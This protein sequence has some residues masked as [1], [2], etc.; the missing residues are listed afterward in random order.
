MV[1]HLRI[2]ADRCEDG[3]RCMA[4]D[5]ALLERLEDEPAIRLYG[6]RRPTLSLGYFQDHDRVLAILPAGAPT[7]IVRR[8]TGGGA[9]WHEHE[10]TYCL[11]GR[12]G[13]HGLPRRTADC[14]PAI[15]DRVAAAL[16]AAGGS[17]IAVQPA[18]ARPPRYHREP[19][20]FA[21]PAAGDLLTTGGAKIL[22]SA[23]RTRGDRIMIHG[24]LKL[25]SNPWDG[26]AAAGCGLPEVA[27][28]DLLRTCLAM[29]FTCPSH[30]D[31]LHADEVAAAERI[32]AERYG[33]DR[34]VRER[35]G[36]RP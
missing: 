36:P 4:V 34:W 33:D 28:R 20:C 25:A 16:A 12:L 15:H 14:Y 1:D 31:D 29:L 13:R 21:A 11:V 30:P 3:A 6:W 17:G 7:V 10:I 24:S 26:T 27:A 35:A 9:I 5:E 23:A 19:R 18:V 32:L 2:L 8:I 22:G